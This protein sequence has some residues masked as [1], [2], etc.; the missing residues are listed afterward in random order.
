[1]LVTML[2]LILVIFQGLYFLNANLYQ[3]QTSDLTWDSNSYSSGISDF[4]FKRDMS[5]WK[6][7]VPLHDANSVYK[8]GKQRVILIYQIHECRH[9]CTLLLANW[10]I[11]APQIMKWQGP[12]V[13]LTDFLTQ[14]VPSMKNQMTLLFTSF[15]RHY[16]I[17]C[18]S[19]FTWA[20]DHNCNK[21]WINQW[22]RST[23]NVTRWPAVKFNC[24]A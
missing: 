22:W 5:I 16:Y 19:S 1:M 13:G 8:T 2:I 12:E 4:I 17:L 21:K 10:S 6:C 7:I 23:H 20:S 15:I 24:H 11:R 3:F 14:K 9:K 18:V